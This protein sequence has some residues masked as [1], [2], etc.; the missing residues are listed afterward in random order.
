MQSEIEQ[1][2]EVVKRGSDFWKEVSLFLLE[3][4]LLNP[5]EMSILRVAVQMD[6]GKLPS[7]KQS[8]VIMGILEKARDEGFSG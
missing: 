6:Q 5:K 4:K 8:A 2:V 1:T 3:R 7:D